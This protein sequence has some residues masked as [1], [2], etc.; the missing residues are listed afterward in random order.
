NNA[1]IVWALAQNCE[2]I[3]LLNDDAILAPGGL[4]QLVKTGQENPR[5]GFVGPLVLHT[6]PDN[7]IQSAGGWLDRR[8][9]SGH[10]A[11]DQPDRGQYQQPE[12]LPWLSGCALLVRSQ[13]VREIGD[14]DERFFLYEE[15]LEWCLRARQ[16]GWEAIFEP[17]VRVWHAGV[18]PEYEPKPYIT[19]YM[20]RN[21][22]LLLEKL[23]A[24]F[25]PWADAILRDARTLLSWSLKP[26][27]RAKLPHRDAL[28]QGVV[29]Y[30]RR[31]WGKTSLSEI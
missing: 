18:S 14:L 30:L 17:R 20:A 24:G 6:A 21:H 12:R 3:L 28:W 4:Q 11:A 1:G 22:L 23:H 7:V 29:D 5:A 15:E 2:W 10:R 25:L 27:W 16:A 8:W 19:Y 31:R 26:K 9:R 13:M